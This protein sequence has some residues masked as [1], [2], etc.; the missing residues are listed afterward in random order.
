MIVV[1][2]H[3]YQSMVAMSHALEHTVLQSVHVDTDH[4]ADGESNANQITL[5]HTLDSLL[6]SLAL[7]WMTKL[8]KSMPKPKPS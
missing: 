6:V 1:I 3:H 4:K 2:S 5:G 7:A 8:P